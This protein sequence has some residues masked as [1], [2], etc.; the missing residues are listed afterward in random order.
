MISDGS[1]ARRQ[2]RKWKDYIKLFSICLHLTLFCHRRRRCRCRHHRRQFA[3]VLATAIWTTTHL[4]DEMESSYTRTHAL[5]TYRKM[6]LCRSLWNLFDNLRVGGPLDAI[7]TKENAYVLF[8][9]RILSVCTHTL[10][11]THSP[12]HST[13]VRCN[14]TVCFIN[15]YLC[16]Y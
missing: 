13:L 6:T 2:A 11:L 7:M 5:K 12:T 9:E 15:K 14:D 10:L 8:S 4:Q 16:Y 1:Q 3:A